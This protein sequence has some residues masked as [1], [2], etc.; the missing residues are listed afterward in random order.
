MKN[1]KRRYEERI[2]RIRVNPM[3]WKK[4]G[5]GGA[6]GQGDFISYSFYIKNYILTIA[7]LIGH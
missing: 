3:S 6:A 1:K 4:R 5:G 2:M 7:K